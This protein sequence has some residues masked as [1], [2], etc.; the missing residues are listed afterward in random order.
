MFER[1]FYLKAPY[2]IVND[3]WIGN[4]GVHF[5]KLSL[6]HHVS[7]RYVAGSQF[8][9][10]ASLLPWR[11]LDNRVEELNQKSHLQVTIDDLYYHAA[12]R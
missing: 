3:I 1:T 7:Y 10:Q 6:P 5:L 11:N 2:K 4:P 8:Y 9:D 12:E